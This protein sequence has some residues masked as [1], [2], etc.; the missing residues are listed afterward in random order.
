MVCGMHLTDFE[1]GVRVYIMVLTDRDKLC[2]YPP[3]CVPNPPAHYESPAEKI[4][5]INWWHP[6]LQGYKAVV[7]HEPMGVYHMRM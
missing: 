4:G 2:W 7:W 1:A 3:P 5:S 6:R